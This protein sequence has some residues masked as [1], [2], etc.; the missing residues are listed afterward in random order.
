[1]KCALNLRISDIEELIQLK[2]TFWTGQGPGFPQLENQVARVSPRGKL[3][4]WDRLS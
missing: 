1:M 4:Q 2:H 3:L